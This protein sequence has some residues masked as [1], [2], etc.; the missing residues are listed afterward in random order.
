MHTRRKGRNTS[1][2]SPTNQVE[3]SD[4]EQLTIADSGAMEDEETIDTKSGDK[5][6]VTRSSRKSLKIP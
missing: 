3:E 4:E 2:S 6:I 1:S 5:Q